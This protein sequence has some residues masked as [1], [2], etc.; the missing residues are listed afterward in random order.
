MMQSNRE[1]QIDFDSLR[2]SMDSSP[3]DTVFFVLSY[4]KD[5][6]R[7]YV[8]D[9]KK[10]RWRSKVLRVVVLT[11]GTAGTVVP[12]IS[13]IWGSI[14]LGIGYLLLAT[15]ALAYAVDKFFNLSAS[16]IRDQLTIHK[17]ESLTIAFIASLATAGQVAGESLERET[18]LKAIAYLQ[19]LLALTVDE[20]NSWADDFQSTQELLATHN[21]STSFTGSPSRTDESN[22]LPNADR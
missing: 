20:T 22:K 1:L 3:E 16:W 4:G 6:R 10:K 17:I 12:T 5:V 14:P 8:G 15:A 9:K 2:E 21:F 11:A 18:L 19:D 7:W 13:S